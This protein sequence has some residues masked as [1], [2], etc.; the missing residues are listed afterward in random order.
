MQ[1]RFAHNNFNVKNLEESLAF[2]DKALGLKE[3][4]RIARLY[5]CISGRRRDAAPLGAD[6]A[7]GAPAGV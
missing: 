3:T 7:Q 5:H 4:G 2:Y 1:F 6:L